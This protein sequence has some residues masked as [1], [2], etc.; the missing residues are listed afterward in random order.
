MELDPP[1]APPSQNNPDTNISYLILRLA[2]G[3]IGIALPI[4]LVIGP[5]ILEG[6]TELQPSIS[7]Y[8]YSIM[9]V[10]FIFSLSCL[11]I[12]LV[13]YRSRNK[14]ENIV[15]NLAGFFAIG[16]AVFPTSVDGFNSK[17]SCQYITLVPENNPTIGI[18]HYVFAV[19]LFTCFSIFCLK[20][21]QRPDEPNCNMVKKKR[22]NIT[23]KLCGWVIVIS[24]AAIAG[25][26]FYHKKHP[27]TFPYS[28][29]IFETTALVFF[30]ISWFLKGTL[31][32]KHS[33]AVVLK[34]FR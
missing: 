23:Y 34:Y 21:F 28:T 4:V 13:T 8:Y 16:I 26:S 20:I 1:K 33:K 17:M 19:L 5:M 15:S 7:H 2:I 32:W 29:F 12:F 22:R 11:G 10:V 30:G 25:F 31:L 9:H 18:V 3:V 14:F 24:M 6:C 27:D